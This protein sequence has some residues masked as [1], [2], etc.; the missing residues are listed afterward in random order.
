MRPCNL[1]ARILEHVGHCTLQNTDAAAAA[2]R[3]GVKSG[4]VFTRR[5][6]AS[7]SFNADQSDMCVRNER[8]KQP[9]RILPD[10]DTGDECAW[11][12]SCYR[13]NVL[14]SFEPDYVL[15]VAHDQL[16]TILS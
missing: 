3:A 12:S 15:K 16:I 14:S 13:Q 10:S 11:H 9:D 1:T 7:S 5:I 6:A 2:C 4:G 8:M